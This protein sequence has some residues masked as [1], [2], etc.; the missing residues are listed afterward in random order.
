[1]AAVLCFCCPGASVLAAPAV[2][3]SIQP[4]LSQLVQLHIQ[5][6]FPA[7]LSFLALIVYVSCIWY[8]ALLFLAGY[9]E[10]AGVIGSMWGP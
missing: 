8:L 4:R 2:V 9:N 7:Q 1:M 6:H 5:N 3:T 10:S